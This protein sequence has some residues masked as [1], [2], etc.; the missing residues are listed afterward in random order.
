MLMVLGGRRGQGFL[1]GPIWCLG[2]H[3]TLAPL[4]HYELILGAIRELS[5]FG[6][7]LVKQVLA[8]VERLKFFVSCALTSVDQISDALL[9]LVVDLIAAVERNEFLN[10]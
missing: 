6:V 10:G 2:L 4:L 5:I 1:R 9:L 7:I 3:G 8:H